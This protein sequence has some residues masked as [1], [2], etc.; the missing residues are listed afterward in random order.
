LGE[1]IDL[2]LQRSR[3]RQTGEAGAGFPHQ[4]THATSPT[5]ATP[6]T[7]ISAELEKTT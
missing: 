5:V 2:P 6:K 7:K 3:V 1:Q 4:N